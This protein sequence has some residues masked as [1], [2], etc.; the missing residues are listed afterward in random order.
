MVVILVNQFKIFISL[1]LFIFIVSFISSNCIREIK[2]RENICSAIDILFLHCSFV[3]ITPF[4]QWKVIKLNPLAWIVT[5]LESGKKKK[6]ILLFLGW[7]KSKVDKTNYFK[8][9]KIIDNLEPK[10]VFDIKNTF[11]YFISIW[12]EYHCTL[13][14]N[15][16]PQTTFKSIE[17]KR[18]QIS[19][20][21][22]IRWQLSA[23]ADDNFQILSALKLLR[24]K[25][26]IKVPDT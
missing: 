24:S 10:Q 18:G 13:N 19:K 20:E 21:Y 6:K 8:L 12:R 14:I 1:W 2:Q 11:K 4:T 9:C 3:Y 5:K 17:L 22:Q 23:I 25:S 7:L 26:I 15:T 16:W